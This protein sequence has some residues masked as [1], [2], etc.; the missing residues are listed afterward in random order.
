MLLWNNDPILEYKPL[1]M[2]WGGNKYKAMII[3]TMSFISEEEK[4][5]KNIETFNAHKPFKNGALEQFLKVFAKNRFNEM[6]ETQQKSALESLIKFLDN[7]R[8][9]PIPYK[10]E[11]IANPLKMGDADSCRTSTQKVY[12]FLSESSAEVEVEN[13]DFDTILKNVKD[14]KNFFE[15]SKERF[16]KNQMLC[17]AV[18]DFI[19]AFTIQ[20]GFYIGCKSKNVVKDFFGASNYVPVNKDSPYF[21]KI[22]KDVYSYFLGFDTEYKDFNG[23]NVDNLDKEQE[24]DYYT[25]FLDSTKY[26]LLVSLQFARQIHKNIFINT[27]ILPIDNARFN[28][29]NLLYHTE[30]WFLS[31]F[32]N[33]GLFDVTICGHKNIVDLS[34]LVGLK[35]SRY[36]YTIFSINNC[37]VTKSSEQVK[38]KDLSD[39][40][41]TVGWFS[42]RDSLILQAPMS[43]NKLGREIGFH[44]FVLPEGAIAKMDLFLKDYPDL[45][46]SYALRDS[47]ISVNFLYYYYRSNGFNVPMTVAQMGAKDF[48]NVVCSY[49]NWKKEDFNFIYRGLKVREIYKGKELVYNTVTEQEIKICGNHYHGGRNETFWHGRFDGY[50]Q[51]VDCTSFYPTLA[52]TIPMLD[53]NTP[54]YTNL[55]GKFSRLI[56]F[57]VV[58]LAVNQVGMLKVDFDFSKCKEDVIP[59][60]TIS[61]GKHGLIF[62]TKGEG[63]WVTLHEL[64]S[65]YALG[66]D[67]YSYGGFI[68]KSLD[69]YENPF[70]VYFTDRLNERAKLK[71]AGEK[72]K[73]QLIKLLMNSVTGK[74]GQSLSEKTTFDFSS[75]STKKIPMSLI[76]NA[77]YVMTITS[78]GRAVITEIMN[79]FK[80]R[81]FDI[82]NVVTDGFI[83]STGLEISDDDLNGMILEDVKTEA[84]KYPNLVIYLKEL[85]KRGN[86]NFVA[87]KHK[88]EK[89]YPI[90]TRVCFLW[91]NAFNENNCQIAMTGY[92]ENKEESEMPIEQKIPYFVNKIGTREGRI[93]NESKLLLNARKLKNGKSENS[94]TKPKKLDFNYDFKRDIVRDSISIN[95]GIFSFK[96]KPFIDKDSFEK[97]KSKYVEHKD[98]QVIDMDSFHKID[99]VADLKAVSPFKFLNKDTT[100][101]VMSKLVYSIAKAN[102]LYC[103][104]RIVNKRELLENLPNIVSGLEL[105]EK[106]L[107][108]GY[109]RGCKVT[110]EQKEKLFENKNH[111]K[112]Q[113]IINN[114]YNT[115]KFQIKKAR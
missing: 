57:K 30:Q 84:S 39:N 106:V 22:K 66:C 79:L 104:N 51:D 8:Y 40:Y 91:D 89:C 15:N 10:N 107:K 114:Y 5:I 95:D 112:I 21:E 29:N 33:K 27:I 35:D 98:I 92:K 77:P 105:S 81:G 65:A 109:L 17:E 113:K 103:D 69:N 43:L 101:D 68:F 61:A 63:V 19:R 60:I 3:H 46:Y 32:D 4:K 70:R 62:P 100:L 36:R 58:D 99:I 96:T 37:L 82:V 93:V 14:V 41:K 38:I 94:V 73:E 90:R 64:K 31:L 18:G 9:Y 74:S 24:V 28:F 115:D 13:F 83:L 72:G 49:Y 59:C 76:T 20:D 86:I 54:P 48:V 50:F 85:E 53:L 80:A 44:K 34:K 108:A 2:T 16:Y 78:M 1:T 26:N 45:F 97:V 12:S 55:E 71:K 11:D 25:R 52:S 87:T 67:I 42:L 47:Q 23:L 7:L 75:N 6:Q 111:L 88:G 56:D 102:F 110:E